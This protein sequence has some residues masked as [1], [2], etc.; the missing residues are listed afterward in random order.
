M[1]NY[2]N[3]L[4]NKILPVYVGASLGVEAFKNFADTTFI[5]N[6]APQK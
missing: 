4:S 6:F 2:I 5:I 1:Q 3:F